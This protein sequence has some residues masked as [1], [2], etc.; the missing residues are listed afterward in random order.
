MANSHLR[1]MI[2]HTFACCKK[3]KRKEKKLQY[4][5]NIVQLA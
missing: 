2:F 3:M 5:E 4:H 1:S